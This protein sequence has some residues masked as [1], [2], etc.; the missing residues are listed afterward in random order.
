MLTK[1]SA[2]SFL[3]LLLSP[4]LQAEALTDGTLGSPVHLTDPHFSSFPR[5]RMGMQSRRAR[6]F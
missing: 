6:H 2:C 5:A 3:L 1:H 4:P